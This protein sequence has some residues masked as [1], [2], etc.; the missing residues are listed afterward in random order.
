[1][2]T[3]FP[4]LEELVSAIRRSNAINLI[5]EGSDDIVV[6][7]VLEREL[8]KTLEQMIVLVPAGGRSQLLEIHE[9]LREEPAIERC[10]FICDLGNV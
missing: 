4:T 7:R 1:M 5:V 2:P 9:I 3:P 6:Y 8:V 10:I